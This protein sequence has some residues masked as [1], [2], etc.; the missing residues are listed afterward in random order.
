M[1]SRNGISVCRF[2]SMHAFTN[3]ELY[4]G[5][6]AQTAPSCEARR[7]PDNSTFC[8]LLLLFTVTVSRELACHPGDTGTEI[9]IGRYS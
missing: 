8:G 7:I 4:Y 9:Y 2:E 3:G 5:T 6:S 1:E